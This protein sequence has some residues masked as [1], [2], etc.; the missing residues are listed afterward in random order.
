MSASFGPSALVTPANGVTLARVAFTPVLLAMVAD[1]G[2]SYPALALWVVLA[3]TDGLDGY[4]ARRHGTT[5]SGAF[6][7]PLADKLLVL[8]AMVVLAVRGGFWWVPV[9]LIAGREV[10]MSAYRSWVGRRGV[11]IPARWSAKVKTVVQEV[12]VGCALFPPLADGAPAVADAVLWVAVVLTLVSGV[13]Y[14]LDGAGSTSGGGV[15][16]RTAGAG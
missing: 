12:A 7:D 5:R 2:A 9:A 6:L 15:N 1:S 16:S 8:G 3:A 11:S 13:Q 10:A 14:L 4:L